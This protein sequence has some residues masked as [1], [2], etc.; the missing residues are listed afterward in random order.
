MIAQRANPAAI[1]FVL[2]QGPDEETDETAQHPHSCPHVKALLANGA[3]LTI[4]DVAVQD[5]GDRCS[6]VQKTDGRDEAV[7][8]RGDDRVAEEDED[9]DGD[10]D[11]GEDS[12]SVRV[13]GLA[14][15]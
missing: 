2:A 13:L 15:C 7:R 10:E 9:D 8:N 6:K 11:R 4:H 3:D 14:G 12:L 5:P 1:T